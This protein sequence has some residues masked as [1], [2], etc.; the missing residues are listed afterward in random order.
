MKKFTKKSYEAKTATGRAV[1]VW[2]ELPN[3]TSRGAKAF[4]ATN[5][6]SI[7][8]YRKT[9]KWFAESQAYNIAVHQLQFDIVPLLEPLYQS[10]LHDLVSGDVDENDPDNKG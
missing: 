5:F 1:D 7:C 2:F 3:S 4:V 9:G 8:F 6:L 10:Y